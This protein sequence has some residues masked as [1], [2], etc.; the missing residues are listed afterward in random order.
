METKNVWLLGILGFLWVTSGQNSW[1][2]KGN[3]NEPNANQKSNANQKVEE[4]K[5]EHDISNISDPQTRSF[6]EEKAIKDQ[7]KKAKRK[8]A[9]NQNRKTRKDISDSVKMQVNLMKE[10]EK[11]SQ[12]CDEELAKLE[13]EWNEIWDDFR[14]S[15]EDRSKKAS[16]LEKKRDIASNSLNNY[17]RWEVELE[18]MQLN[19]KISEST[20]AL[21]EKFGNILKKYANVLL[22]KKEVLDNPQTLET[23]EEMK[24]KERMK[25]FENSKKQMEKS[26]YAKTNKNKEAIA[27]LN[28]FVE[29]NNAISSFEEKKLQKILQ[30]MKDT[31][32][33]IESCIKKHEQENNQEDIQNPSNLKKGGYEDQEEEKKAQ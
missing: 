9:K 26:Y 28:E 27:R 33:D 29:N 23:E 17:E 5:K 7:N 18:F 13:L 12:A 16:I 19:V 30:L 25:E 8:E 20:M 14:V 15:K 4:E 2:G 10:R 1:G 32:T 3:E 21:F 6:E 31:V 22:K 11:F 24:W